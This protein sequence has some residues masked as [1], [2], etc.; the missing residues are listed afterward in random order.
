LTTGGRSWN[1]SRRL[2]FLGE[3]GAGSGEQE[4]G[5]EERGENRESGI[6]NRE[7]GIGNRES[8]IEDRGCRHLMI[9]LESRQNKRQP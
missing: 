1:I 9:F 3:R 5:S 7:S 6:G 4:A 8:G 2:F